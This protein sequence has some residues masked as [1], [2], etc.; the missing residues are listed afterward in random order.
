MPGGTYNKHL[1]A[2][3]LIGAFAAA[4]AAVTATNENEETVINALSLA[5][6]HACG[7]NEWAWTG[8]KE[9]V[10]QNGTASRAG[11]ISYDLARCGV[12][13]SESVLGG[14]DGLF[15][16][17]DAGP[18]AAGLF[19]NWVRTS[20]LGRGLLDV[21]FK[22]APTCNFTQTSSALALKIARGHGLSV[23]D[24]E[25]VTVTT[26]S[27]ANAY[28]GCHNGGPLRSA[29]QGK[30]SIQYGVS[31]A[32]VFGRL[33]EETLARV[34]DETVNAVMGRC[35]VVSD[36]SS[37]MDYKRGLQPAKVRV[38]LRDGGVLEE[39]AGDVPWLNG[40]EVKTRFLEEISPRLAPQKAQRLIDRCMNLGN[41]DIKGDLLA[42]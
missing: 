32:L 4:A 6:N 35:V 9:L 28:P 13:S 39:S 21:R 23:E 26:T 19:A 30:L 14:K 33:D 38:V 1:R 2:S 18:G 41:V 31:A 11:I 15:A 20:Q 37:D 10:V 8:T 17:V 22:P 40:E 12:V 42:V 25:R 27:A 24:V 3:G 29:A 36:G 7:F 16:A 5:V 34:D